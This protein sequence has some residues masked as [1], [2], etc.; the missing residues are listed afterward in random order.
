L[1][2]DGS[3]SQVLFRQAKLGKDRRTK[4]PEPSYRA[5]GQAGTVR[6]MNAGDGKPCHALPV[7]QKKVRGD[8][9]KK[10][11]SFPGGGRSH[12]QKKNY[13]RH[14]KMKALVGGRPGR[15]R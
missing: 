8:Q 2:E 3:S 5:K 10:V 9:S 1:P 4:N 11:K 13:K 12:G 6:P 14:L 15:V 7:T